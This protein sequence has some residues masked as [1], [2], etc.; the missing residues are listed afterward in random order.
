M[1]SPLTPGPGQVPGASVPVE[2]LHLCTDV[3]RFLRAFRGLK[4]ANKLGCPSLT[5]YE[6]EKQPD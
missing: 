1:S 4:T 3:E 2:G 5:T 6:G